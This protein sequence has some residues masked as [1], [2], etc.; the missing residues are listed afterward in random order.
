M[1]Y[2]CGN[3]ALG[4]VFG[5]AWAWCT[6]GGLAEGIAKGVVEGVARVGTTC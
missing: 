4:N 5:C 2:V 1:V 3:C 6:A